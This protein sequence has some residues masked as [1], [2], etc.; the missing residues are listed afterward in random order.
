MIFC[1]VRPVT[2][3]QI[4]LPIPDVRFPIPDSRFPIPDSRSR[5]HMRRYLP[6]LALLAAA[7]PMGAQTLPPVRPIGETVARSTEPMGSVS[8]AIALPGGKVL[9]NDILKRR[10][11]LL[12]S[13]LTEVTVVA[14]S[15]SSTANAYG[16]R[17]GGLLAYRGDSALFVDPASMSMLVINSE[18]K[19]TRVMSAPRPQDVGFLIGGPNGTPGFDAKGRLV[20]RAQPRITRMARGG[21]SGPML[22]EFPDSALVVRFDLGTRTLD[23][24]GFFRINRLNM[25]V[26]QTAS[27]GMMVTSTINPIPTVDD[28]ALLADGTIAFVKGA[29]YSITWVRPDGSTESTGKVPYEWQRLDEDGKAALLDSARAAMEA[30]REKAQQ[31][32]ASGQAVTVAP[33]GGGAGP[34]TAFRMGATAAGAPPA[35]GG[36]APGAA[37]T[38]LEMPPINMVNAD[39]LPDYRPAFTAGAARGD[40]EGNLWVRTTS[41]VGNAGPIYFVINTKGEVID[42]VQFPEGRLL[43]GFGK[44]GDVFLAL[45]DADG[46]ARVETAKVR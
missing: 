33:G 39:Q 2:S 19:I 8:T 43:V 40:L 29:D 22:P 34:E 31:Q 36:G 15:T 28:W 45:R 27:G 10:V 30:A 46:N 1:V 32:L 5:F 37:G 23:T 13:T 38:R 42:R 24:A 35:R 16:N 4:L 41:P 26:T 12:D 17:A 9:V 6:F 11:L 7:A 20:Y 18:G 14:D 3:H 21:G 44:N 25:T